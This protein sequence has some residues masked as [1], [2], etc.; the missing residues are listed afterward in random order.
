M[1]C[2]LV[3]WSARVCATVHPPLPARFVRLLPPRRGERA[4]SFSDSLCAGR[5]KKKE[6][7]S[8]WYLTSTPLAKDRQRHTVSSRPYAKRHESGNV[9]RGGRSLFATV[10]V[11]LLGVRSCK[12]FSSQHI[13]A[14]CCCSGR[15]PGP[16]SLNP[17]SA[18]SYTLRCGRRRN[19]PAPHPA[20]TR[21]SGPIRRCRLGQAFS[22]SPFTDHSPA[23]FSGFLPLHL[24][25]SGKLDTHTY[26]SACELTH[27]R[28]RASFTRLYRPGSHA[29]APGGG[30]L[31]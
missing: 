14:R 1:S 16:G 25:P 18:H 11:F 9:R 10:F 5:K 6:T 19:A 26:I 17:P 4:A 22:T 12:A 21:S 13:T 20:S 23:A 7:R 27:A 30:S 3:C 28:V 24:S 31:R 15:V 8:S 2:F 29:R